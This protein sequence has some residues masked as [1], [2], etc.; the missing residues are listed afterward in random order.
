ME[1][2]VFSVYD[3]QSC[4]AER[5][6]FPSLFRWNPVRCYYMSSLL[7]S[8]QL[9]RRS[10]IPKIDTGRNVYLIGSM[11]NESCEANGPTSAHRN[12]NRV[13]ISL[14]VI[15]FLSLPS[16]ARSFVRWFVDRLAHHCSCYFE[17]L[18]SLCCHIFFPYFGLLLGV[19]MALWSCR[20]VMV[21]I[22]LG[23]WLRGRGATWT[24]RGRRMM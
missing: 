14:S 12:D 2:V 18:K 20:N 21:E 13:I 6:N 24:M 16:A 8:G 5:L 17:C 19:V 15:A 23:R 3:L 10:I 22:F 11:P 9:F 7:H 1:C 4:D